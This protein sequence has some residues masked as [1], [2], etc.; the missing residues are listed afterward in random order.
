MEGRSH[1]A[2]RHLVQHIERREAPE[3]SALAARSQHAILHQVNQT[4]HERQAESRVSP[5][6][7]RDVQG[8]EGAVRTR[9]S[10]NGA[11]GK[12]EQCDPDYQQKG[13]ECADGALAVNQLERKVGDG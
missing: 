5:G 11:R 12:V 8:E 1:A 3:S 6:V 7:Q 10:R 9:R 2:A 13:D 4:K